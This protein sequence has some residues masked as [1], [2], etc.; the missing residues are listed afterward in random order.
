MTFPTTT[1]AAVL[2]ITAFAGTASAQQPAQMPASG[3]MPFDGRA[4][5]SIQQP[6]ASRAS[7]RAEANAA[8]LQVGEVDR[9]H[10]S[11]SS[12]PADSRLAAPKAKPLSGES[13]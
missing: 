3:E 10:E 6:A 13:A 2:L 4:E 7:V 8:N 11:A 9:P 12:A 1:T 5:A